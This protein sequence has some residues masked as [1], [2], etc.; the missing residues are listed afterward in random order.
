M[1]H[2]QLAP[3][4]ALAIV[5]VA[6]V[7]GL[8]AVSPASAAGPTSQAATH[9]SATTSPGSNSS[10]HAQSDAPDVAALIANANQR[11]AQTDFAQ[12][13]KQ[14]LPAGSRLT[15]VTLLQAASRAATPTSNPA[16]FNG[17]QIVYAVQYEAPNGS[18]I[19][20]SIAYS[21]QDG[22]YQ[23]TQ[24][25][26]SLFA[27]NL[28]ESSPTS[29]FASAM[30]SMNNYASAHLPTGSAVTDVVY[31]RPNGAHPWD[32]GRWIFTLTSKQSFSVDA[33]GTVIPVGLIG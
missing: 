32:S 11:N 18:P 5:P 6:L 14:Y 13:Y 22:H 29:S 4:F 10:H 23:F 7:S 33:S 19:M 27:G 8:F 28:T 20:H 17:W 16:D 1:K 30:T 21:Y 9:A 24:Y 31:A 25:A 12:Q 15:G 3:Q 2:L 26:P